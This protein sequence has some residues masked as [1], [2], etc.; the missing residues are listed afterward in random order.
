MVQY[1]ILDVIKIIMVIPTVIFYSY[2][3]YRLILVWYITTYMIETHIASTT[4]LRTQTK[5]GLKLFCSDYVDAVLPTVK[6]IIKHISQ[7]YTIDSYINEKCPKFYLFYE[8]ICWFSDIWKISVSGVLFFLS[9][10]LNEVWELRFAGE[11]PCANPGES[12][13][14]DEEELA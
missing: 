6:N 14:N 9:I 5:I 12:R 2:C 4:C 8:C 11:R 3:P 7:F 1:R 10:E 13:E